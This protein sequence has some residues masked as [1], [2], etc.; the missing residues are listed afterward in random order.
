LPHRGSRC[1]G[2]LVGPFE[3]VCRNGTVRVNL[4]PSQLR[5]IC[6]NIGIVEG[7]C[8]G[9]SLVTRPALQ[10]RTE[11][12]VLQLW[13]AGPNVSPFSLEGV[14]LK[15]SLVGPRRF[16]P[17]FV[18]HD[19]LRAV[20]LYNLFICRTLDLFRAAGFEITPLRRCSWNCVFL[21]GTGEV[22]F[23]FVIH[24]VDIL[25]YY[26]GNTK[27]LSLYSL[28]EVDKLIISQK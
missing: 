28:L 17:R 6:I 14:D 16:L 2:A 11:T 18:L 12:A 7:V 23:R 25:H 22:L 1:V 26:F 27:I 15:V 20:S 4:R 19:P 9:K 10:G 3:F 13:T 21:K 5:N 24:K 8:P